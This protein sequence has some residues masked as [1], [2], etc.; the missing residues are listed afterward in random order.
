MYASENSASGSRDFCDS[1][2]M[3]APLKV[4]RK[5]Q[6]PKV[7]PE[8]Q[9]LIAPLKPEERRQLEANL[10]AQGCR[11]AV[12]LWNGIILDGHNRAEICARLGI[13]YKTSSIEL[14]DREAAKLWIEENQVGRRN[15]TPDQRAA[16]AFRILC[17]RVA[18]SKHLRARKG[19]LARAGIS[20]VDGA[21]PKQGTEPQRKRLREIAADQHGVSQR[22]LR[23]ISEIAKCDATLTD[24]I[25]AGELT[26]R[27]AKEL[28]V[29]NARN[30][31]RRAALKCN[32]KGCGIYT[33]DFALLQR[34]VPD[35]S[36]DLFLT[37]P[38]YHAAA[39]P[40]YG[41][42]AELA[43][44]KL[45]PG[46]LC[47]VMCGQLHLA[48]I[49][50]EMTKHLDYYWLCAVRQ[51]GPAR[52]RIWPR[53]ISNKFKPVLIFVKRPSP[54]RATHAFLTDLILG[55]RDKE[56]HW[57]GQGAEEFRY[58][59]E[60]LTEPEQLCVDPF[61][62][63]G[64]VP[65]ACVATNRRFIG[66]ELDPGVAAAARARIAAFRKAMVSD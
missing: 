42:L 16:I 3:A 31:K 38:E 57:M 61:C 55:T 40:V 48:E 44:K 53:K 37:D 20:L 28:L 54:K 10:I 33:G 43:Q 39:I 15:L 50:A 30:A 36:V 14:P 35:N 17:R 8:F 29:E 1:K 19:G 12:I 62:G 32:P 63:G 5:N 64:T 2:S 52:C 66:T 27:K 22:S 56:H 45:K 34:L 4:V 58:F 24:R 26:I 13:P 18:A 21:A 49:L 59:I 7:D 25:V 6:A 60:R 46:R 9:A 41:R 65:E 23:A 51:T 47:A 11:D